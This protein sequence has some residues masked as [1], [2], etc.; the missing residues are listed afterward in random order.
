MQIIKITPHNFKIILSPTDM[1]SYGE[2]IFNY[3]EYNEK[4]FSDIINKT[5]EIYGNPFSEGAV[6]ASVFE[7]KDGGAEIFLSAHAVKRGGA[8]YIFSTDS[9][10]DLTSLCVSL[11]ARCPLC[12]SVL[13][14]CDGIYCLILTSP[15]E[16]YLFLPF[17]REFGEARN[18][19]D[20]DIW[21]L[22]EH[23]KLLCAKN[24]VHIIGNALGHSS[25]R[26]ESDTPE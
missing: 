26:K 10:D 5:N 25:S 7:S 19:S 14:L 11:E 15:S 17:L 4:L 24:A 1:K 6:D 2:N 9:L 13:Y 23:A 20:C 22:E 18:C 8:S 21:H 3:S 12:K 16:K